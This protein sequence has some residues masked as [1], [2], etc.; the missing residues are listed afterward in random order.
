MKS[1]YVIDRYVTCFF[2][3]LYFSE[4]CSVADDGR[5]P[6]SVQRLLFIIELRSVATDMTLAA[7]AP[8]IV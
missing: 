7:K 4:S 8:E 2:I 1:T 5:G 3:I 6:N